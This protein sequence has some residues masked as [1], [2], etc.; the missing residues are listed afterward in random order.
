MEHHTEWCTRSAGLLARLFGTEAALLLVPATEGPSLGTRGMDPETR[1]GFNRIVRPSAPGR[2]SYRDPVLDRVVSRLR[3]A[4]LKAWNSE[5]AERITRIKQEKMAFHHE[6]LLPGRIPYIH[7]T[8]APVNPGE[9]RLA[10]FHRHPEENPYG[11]DALE[12]LHMLRPALEAGLRGLQ[13]S[14][15]QVRWLGTGL[16]QVDAGM[17]L[18]S[19]D[20]RELHRN[21]VLRRC[22]EAGPE[23][24]RLWATVKN[25][26][27]RV[28]R[29]LDSEWA[30][31]SP[32]PVE[33]TIGGRRYLVS[34]SMGGLP[35]ASRSAV[36][37]TVD[38]LDPLLPPVDRL[39]EWFGLTKRQATIAIL[40]AEG[41]SN[42]EI[43]SFLGISPHTVRNHA[44][45]IFDKIQVRSRKALGLFLARY[46]RYGPEVA[47]NLVPPDVE[48]TA[49]APGGV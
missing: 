20:G 3:A 7:I 5:L 32:G 16:E 19:G 24:A 21:A 28:L 27:Q 38:R 4:G 1:E 34:G 9:A 31:P 10:V 48:G 37:V 49:E 41:Q 30:G 26:S 23:G 47:E 13:R 6:V 2:N 44:A 14:R 35:G 46:A 8:G 39:K 43:A 36:L 18:F 42:T 40:L 33:I 45:A 22:V 29:T 12:L 17:A 15:D 11:E 25:T